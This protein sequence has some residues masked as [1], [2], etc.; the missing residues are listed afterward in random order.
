MLSK[1]STLDGRCSM[2]GNRYR[3]VLR[4]KGDIINHFADR[5]SL[6]RGARIFIRNPHHFSRKT[7]PSF[8]KSS[9]HLLT[10]LTSAPAAL[11][12][13]HDTTVPVKHIINTMPPSTLTSDIES[14]KALVQE[15]FQCPVCA[16]NCTGAYVN[17][18]CMHRFCGKCLPEIRRCNNACPTCTI[19]IRFLLQDAQFDKI[20][21]RLY[22]NH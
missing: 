11:N 15:Q 12:Y 21:S 5:R 14:L 16:G 20:V 19:N 2:I 1:L 10:H 13:H 3:T 22:R 17:P 8:L 18:E 7:S 9:Y 4:R 6:F